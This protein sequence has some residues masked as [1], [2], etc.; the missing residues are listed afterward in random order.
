[1]DRLRGGGSTTG[2]VVEPKFQRAIVVCDEFDSIPKKFHGREYPPPQPVK[3]AVDNSE[4]G[5]AY[6]E[7]RK[8]GT[9]SP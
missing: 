4:L 7:H 5:D 6:S 2:P 8:K 9:I 3:T 1:V